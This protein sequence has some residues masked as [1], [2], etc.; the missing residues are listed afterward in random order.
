MSRATNV[1]QQPLSVIKW[2][3]ATRLQAY[4]DFGKL[5]VSTRL[6]ASGLDWH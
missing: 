1:H 6:D 5:R 2:Q 4:K 3:A